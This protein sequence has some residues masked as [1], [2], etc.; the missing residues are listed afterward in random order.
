MLPTTAAELAP[1]EDVLSVPRVSTYRVAVGGDLRAALELYGWN[2]EI[3]AALMLPAHFA[4]V[5][6][7]NAACDALSAV[8][9]PRWPWNQS[10]ELSLTNSGTYNPRRDLIETRKRQSTPG[11]VVAELK[12]VFWQRLFTSRFDTRLWDGRI[13]TV[14]PHAPAGTAEASLRARIYADLDAIRKL[15]NRLA[16]HEPIFTRNLG[17]DLA[18]MLELIE[19][20]SRETGTWVRGLETASSLVTVRPSP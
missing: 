13:L 8:Y 1:I 6:T 4:E 17:D 18:R 16:H 5:A 12:F 3:S 14:F 20:R 11:K 7:R 9:G 10:F 19:I 15:R 2:A